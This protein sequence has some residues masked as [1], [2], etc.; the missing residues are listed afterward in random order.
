M[1]TISAPTVD[2]LEDGYA[3][4]DESSLGSRY[5]HPIFRLWFNLTR[6]EADLG[7]IIPELNVEMLRKRLDKRGHHS[8]FL[9]PRVYGKGIPSYVEIYVKRVNWNGWP[10]LSLHVHD[11]SAI[12]EKDALI[13]SHARIIEHSNRKLKRLSENLESENRLLQETMAEAREAR[14][15]A[16]EANRAKSAFLANMSHELRTP[17][18]AIIGYSE[19]LAEEA[20]DTGREEDLADLQK[21]RTAGKHLLALINDVL[22]L[23]KI[24][25]GKMELHLETF[26]VSTMIHDVLTTISPLVAKNGN[27]L[28][29]DEEGDLGE[30][31]A[32]LIKLRQALLNLLSNATKFTS[33]GV[34]TLIARREAGKGGDW[35]RLAVSDTGIGISEEQL[36][37]LFQAFSQADASTSRKYGGTGLGLVISRRFCHMM[38]GDISV[39]SLAGQGSTFT[40]RLPY[41]LTQN[42]EAGFEAPSPSVGEK[43]VALVIDDDLT[44]QELMRTFLTGHGLAVVHAT[45]GEEGLRLAKEIRPAL[46]TLDVLMPEMDGWAVL[47]HL[48]ADPELAFIPVVMVTLGED[49]PRGFALGATDFL[50]KPIERNDFIRLLNRYRD[51][52]DDYPILLVEDDPGVRQMMGRLLEKE[53]CSLRFAENGRVALERVAEQ[54]PALIVLDLMMPEMDGFE[55]IEALRQQPDWRSIPIVVL[56]AKDLSIEDRRRL[57]GYVERVLDRGTYGHDELLRELGDRIA[58]YLHRDGG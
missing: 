47:A 1:D 20:E 58:T 54:L 28:E 31:R 51:S 6:D 22:D 11:A 27:R 25:A 3:L 5:L 57:N 42:E 32:D 16:E 26:S 35:L 30:L 17:L 12:Q 56:T 29:L 37:K 7:Q 44:A 18:N 14:R 10:C 38:G 40:I 23:S 4:F 13:E 36:T 41:A 33:D 55:V 53:A 21:I 45:N 19:I 39:E 50:T 24:E 8:F 49:Q 15:D 48:K 52:R 43:P 34:I 2:L 9:T 46:I